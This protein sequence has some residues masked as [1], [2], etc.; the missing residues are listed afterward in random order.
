MRLPRG[1]LHKPLLSFQL[2]PRFGLWQSCLWQ[3]PLSP[4]YSRAFCK[5]CTHTPC[6]LRRQSPCCFLAEENF[7]S[8]THNLSVLPL[9]IHTSW[10]GYKNSTDFLWSLNICKQS[11]MEAQKELYNS[12]WEARVDSL[13]ANP[14]LIPSSIHV[15]RDSW[16]KPFTIAFL[17]PKS[18][19]D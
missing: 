9:S 4:T 11:Q 16:R 15:S 2:Q 5:A 6:S 10:W 12:T 13:R 7:A 1:Q 3:A 8:L 14:A 19:P 17:C 18:T